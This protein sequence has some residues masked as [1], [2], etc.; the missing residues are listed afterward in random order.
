MLNDVFRMKELLFMEVTGCVPPPRPTQP[1][2]LPL[3]EGQ[4]GTEVAME[5]D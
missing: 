1:M 4:R 5:A 2:V 3:T